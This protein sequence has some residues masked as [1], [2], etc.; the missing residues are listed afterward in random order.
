MLLG[1]R[2]DVGGRRR[3]GRAAARP[4][5]AR[6]PTS[7][8][9]SLHGPFGEDGTVQ[10]LLELLD[11]PYVG[12]GRARQRGC[13]WT[14]SSSRSSWRAPGCRRSA[15]RPRRERWRASRAVR[16]ESPA[17]GFPCWVKPARLGSSVGIVRVASAGEVDAALDAG[18]RARPARDRRGRGARAGGR[19][20]RPRPTD[21]PQA[22]QPGE[23]VLPTAARLVRLRGQ[24]RRAA[25]SSSSRRASR[26]A[27]RERVRELAVA[28]LPPRRLQRPGPRGLLRRRRRRCCSTSSTRC[29]AS[30]ETSVYGKLWVGAGLPYPELVDRLAALA[31]R[32][33]PRASAPT[34]F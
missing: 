34:A 16:D 20:L 12:R 30:R 31:R 25:W 2:R 17:L 32:A 33:P 19:V 11:V 23:I 8:S 10:G 14:S 5:A 13:A 21:A 4:R 18:A 3:G 1:A 15:T 27:A 29:P 28:R 26:A 7:S 6:A 22:T 9:R 24:V